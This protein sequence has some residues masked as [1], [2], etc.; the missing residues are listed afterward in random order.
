MVRKKNIFDLE[1]RKTIY[2]FIEKNPGLNI[3]EIS[4]RLKIPPTSLIYH[5]RFLD[6]ID[7]LKEKDHGNC[8]RVY[9][10]DKTSTKEKQ[11]LGL[12]RNENAC[13]I[14]LYSYWMLSVS[15]IE[16]SREL[17]IPPP[18]VSYYLTKM[19]DMDLLEE[20]E[21]KNG[22]IYPLPNLKRY[23]ERKP[24]R[25]EKFYR[26]KNNQDSYIIFK[27]IISHNSSFKNKEIIDYF[28]ESWE[29]YGQEGPFV[30]ENKHVK[31]DEQIDSVI[32][33]FSSLF[34][35]CFCS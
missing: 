5:I 26:R 9:T 18:T 3:R 15:Q 34:P 27:L 10:Y 29:V 22:R 28:I 17:K 25:S 13:K 21:S 14:L 12:L 1:K 11:I 23:I 8:K 7:L 4:R 32:D 16:L 30:K 24:I 35:P 19:V 6:K 2:E 33:V 20:V 31:L